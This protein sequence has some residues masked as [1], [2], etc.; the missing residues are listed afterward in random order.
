MMIFL[1]LANVSLSS[2]DK[3]QKPIVLAT[4]NEA[5]T[6]LSARDVVCLKLTCSALYKNEEITPSLESMRK[7]AGSIQNFCISYLDKKNRFEIGAATLFTILSAFYTYKWH[8]VFMLLFGT[9]VYLDM[10]RQDFHLA[11]L[12]EI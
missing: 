10:R 1:L 2:N 11:L 4:M 5:F 6:S 12:H 8:Y 3:V 9:T 7:S